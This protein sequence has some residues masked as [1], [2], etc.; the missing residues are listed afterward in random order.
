MTT[1]RLD[2]AAFREHLLNAEWM[3]AEMDRRAVKGYE[4]ARDISPDATPLEEGYIASFVI[5]SGR[6]GGTENDRAYAELA[7]T[8]DHAVYVEF[9]TEH[10][11]AHHVLTRAMDVMA[12]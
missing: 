7:N 1:Y 10:Q 11:E 9:G 8:S 4:F 12:Q 5:F 2:R 3:V 6:D